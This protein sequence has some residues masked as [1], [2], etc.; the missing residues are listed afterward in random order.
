MSE[1]FEIELMIW[2]VALDHWIETM[3]TLL[4]VQVQAL[5]RVVKSTI[6]YQLW[7]QHHSTKDAMLSTKAQA[8]LTGYSSDVMIVLWNRLITKVGWPLS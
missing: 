2:N 4:Q 1:W 8:R 7:D 3:I 5:I 6:R